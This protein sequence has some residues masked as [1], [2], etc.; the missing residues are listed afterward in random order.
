MSSLLV[1]VVVVVVVSLIL[2]ANHLQLGTINLPLASSHRLAHA[3]SSGRPEA[4][5]SHLSCCR[6]GHLVRFLFAS[7]RLG[8]GLSCGRDVVGA[9]VSDSSRDDSD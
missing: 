5:S 8:W 1:L 2:R 6:T 3:S 9:N 4:R 7:V